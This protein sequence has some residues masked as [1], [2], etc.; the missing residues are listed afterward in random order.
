MR[1]SPMGPKSFN[2]NISS[3]HE[4]ITFVNE[5]KNW[6]ISTDEVQVSYD[7]LN[8]YP[9]VPLSEATSVI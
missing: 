2:S 6:T 3:F 1:E 4:K 5:A 9:S 7:V 8:L